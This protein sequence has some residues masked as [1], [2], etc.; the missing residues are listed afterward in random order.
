[1]QTE[2]G[3]CQMSDT[4]ILRSNGEYGCTPDPD[5]WKP[6]KGS[7][8]KILNASGSVQT[9]SN[10]TPG[11]LTRRG[12]GTV[13]TITIEPDTENPW[14]GRAGS[15]RGTYTYDDGEDGAKLAPRSGTIDPS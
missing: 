11:C 14:T 9:L 6:P 5:P 13:T 10:I 15:T 8:V 7:D 2:E 3:D 1:M 4:L 12:G